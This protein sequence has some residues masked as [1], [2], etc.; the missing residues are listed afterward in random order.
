MNPFKEA[1]RAYDNELPPE[2]D[3]DGNEIDFK[4]AKREAREEREIDNLIYGDENQE[5]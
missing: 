1:Q 3:E 5:D 4:K 2:V